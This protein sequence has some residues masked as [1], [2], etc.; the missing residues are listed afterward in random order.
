MFLRYNA[1]CYLQST[2]NHWILRNDTDTTEQSEGSSGSVFYTHCSLNIRFVTP[3][4][5]QKTFNLFKKA[6]MF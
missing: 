6:T 4:N 2:Q 3:E 1:P 5:L